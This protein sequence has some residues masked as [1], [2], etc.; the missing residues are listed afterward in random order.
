MCITLGILGGNYFQKFGVF[1]GGDAESNDCWCNP[2]LRIWFSGGQLLGIGS[3]LH[4][5]GSWQPGAPGND[6]G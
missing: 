4:P 5:G 2:S 3:P 6:D 1:V